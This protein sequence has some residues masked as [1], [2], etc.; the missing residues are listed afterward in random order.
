M[1]L[2]LHQLPQFISQ[3]PWFVSEFNHSL[4]YFI[5][6]VRDLDLGIFLSERGRLRRGRGITLK[7]GSFVFSLEVVEDVLLFELQFQSQLSILLSEVGGGGMQTEVVL[8][9]LAQF[10]IQLLHLVLGELDLIDQVLDLARV[11]ILIDHLGESPGLL[12]L[13]PLESGYLL[14][15]LLIVLLGLNHSVDTLLHQFIVVLP[16]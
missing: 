14:L 12:I 6:L 5:R 4:D 7:F 13:D 10:L 9:F 3:R 8:S 2:A 15:E 1:L 11:V 16:L